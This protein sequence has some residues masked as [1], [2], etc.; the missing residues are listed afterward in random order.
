MMEEKSTRPEYGG[1]GLV[2]KRRGSGFRMERR[3]PPRTE[4][5]QNKEDDSDFGA[6]TVLGGSAI[7]AAKSPTKKSR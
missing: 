2:F 7:S 4:E 3:E 1:E 6:N 5:S